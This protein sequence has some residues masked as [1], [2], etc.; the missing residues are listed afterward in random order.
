MADSSD[1]VSVDMEGVPFGG[2]VSAFPEYS[3]IPLVYGF[4]FLNIYRAF[5][6]LP[7]NWNGILVVGNILNL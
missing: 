7:R 2:K 3:S 1:S 5:V 4:C 6:W